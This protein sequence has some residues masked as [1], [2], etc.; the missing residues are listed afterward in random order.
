MRRVMA[1][2]MPVTRR[3]VLHGAASAAVVAGVG[4]AVAPRVVHAAQAARG[5]IPILMAMHIHASFSEGIGSM[6][7]HLAEAERIGVDVIWW[8][9]HD[10]RMVARGY[11][12]DVH[13]SGP[14]EY[15]DGVRLT[16]Q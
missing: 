11:L 16:W 12:T 2:D 15:T 8:T 10:H 7:A 1:G 6:Q 9:E 14:V 5:E 13:F 3:Q 4:G